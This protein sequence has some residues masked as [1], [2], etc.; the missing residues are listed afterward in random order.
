MLKQEIKVK[1]K[2]VIAQSLN[3]KEDQMNISDADLI[4]SLGI[5]SVDALEIFVW[6]ENTFEILIDDDDLNAE[7]LDSIDILTEYV[8]RKITTK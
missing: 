7:L 6:I 3:L 1:I 4:Q 8:Y 2:E 5:N